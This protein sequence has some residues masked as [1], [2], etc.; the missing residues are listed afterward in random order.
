MKKVVL[1]LSILTSLPS[2]AL[3]VG[4]A[5]TGA[6]NATNTLKKSK[7][8]E[9]KSLNDLYAERYSDKLDKSVVLKAQEK[10][11]A[12]ADKSKRE[13]TSGNQREQPASTRW[14]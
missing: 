14:R 3:E 5:N 7:A 2:F 4:E 8:V 13:S 11:Q 1:L 12:Q 10:A 6:D 9:H